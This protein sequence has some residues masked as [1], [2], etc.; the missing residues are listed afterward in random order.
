M[1]GAGSCQPHLLEGLRKEVFELRRDKLDA[2]D[3]DDQ[4]QA[5]QQAEEGEY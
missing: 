1:H 5:E 2:A 3:E 4:H